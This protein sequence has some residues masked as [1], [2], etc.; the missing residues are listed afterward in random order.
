MNMNEWNH[1]ESQLKCWKLRAPSV[2]LK[3]R[4]FPSEPARAADV[5]WPAARPWLV[6][7]LA[8]GLVVMLVSQGIYP[9]WGAL[10]GSQSSNVLATVALNQPLLASYYIRSPQHD[11]NLWHMSFELT[12]ETQALPSA[13]QQ[14]NMD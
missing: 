1:L 10:G 9:Q 8:V 4:L 11:R 14:L 3:S 2:R 5:S 12:N 6:P 7:A 13:D